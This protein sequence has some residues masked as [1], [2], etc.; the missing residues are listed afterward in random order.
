MRKRL[1]AYQAKQKG[2]GKKQSHGQEYRQLVMEHV[3]N[4]ICAVFWVCV[5]V[6][7][8][9]IL[10]LQSQLPLPRRRALARSK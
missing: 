3:L 1:Y 10:C 8:E 5:F 4:M 2:D 7:G 6:N 9:A